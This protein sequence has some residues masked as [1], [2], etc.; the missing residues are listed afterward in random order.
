MRKEAQALLPSFLARFQRKGLM[1]PLTFLVRAPFETHPE[2]NAVSENL[3]LEV[4]GRDEGSVV[5]KL[6]DGAV[7]TTE[8]RK[9]A[10]VEVAETQV[11]ALAI[12]RE[13]RALDERELRDLLNAE[14]PM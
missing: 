6:V 1:E 2:G 8:W 7:H 10:H 14:R 9:G 4:M 12:S 11:N 3:W 13:G 5:G